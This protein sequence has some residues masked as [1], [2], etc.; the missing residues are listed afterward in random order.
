MSKSTNLEI[1]TSYNRVD[2][3]ARI[4][5]WDLHEKQQLKNSKKTVE[6]L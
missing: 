4:L 6:D 5:I 1:V 2:G 3:S